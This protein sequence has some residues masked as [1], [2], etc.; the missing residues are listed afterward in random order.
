MRK[1]IGTAPDGSEWLVKYGESGA[2]DEAYARGA[3]A[4]GI[5]YIPATSGVAAHNGLEYVMMPLVPALVAYCDWHAPLTLAQTFECHAASIIDALVADWDRNAGNVA[6]DTDSGRFVSIDHTFA[7]GR[8]TAPVL[9]MA[10]ALTSSR[11]T[12]HVPTWEAD[13][14]LVR[15]A[16]RIVLDDVA[17]AIADGD[18]TY[19]AQVGMRLAAVLAF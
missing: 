11:Y 19:A 10:H 9:P 18:A 14:R 1:D 5:P 16:S 4:L 12:T 17:L 2:G 8:R 3:E 7:Y 6:I 13:F 15:D